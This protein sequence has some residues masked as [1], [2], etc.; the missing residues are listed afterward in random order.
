[1]FLEI[2]DLVV[3]VRLAIFLTII[4]LGDQG[5]SRKLGH[6]CGAKKLLHN[7]LQMT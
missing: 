5:E 7:I 6:F 2:A 3:G 1:M 4:D